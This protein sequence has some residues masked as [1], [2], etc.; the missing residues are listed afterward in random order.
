MITAWKPAVGQRVQYVFQPW[1]PG[2]YGLIV[3]HVGHPGEL[4][5]QQGYI[6]DMVKGSHPYVVRLQTRIIQ[7]SALEIQPID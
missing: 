7:C 5:G 2:V 3:G 6:Y 1:C 4:D